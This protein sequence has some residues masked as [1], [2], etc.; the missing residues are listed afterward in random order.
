MYKVYSDDYLLYSDQLNNLKIMSPQLQLEVGKIDYFDFEVYPNH[1]YYN[2]INKLKS[3]I[4]VYQ[5]DDIIFRGRARNEDKGFYNQKIFEC[6]S[7]LSFLNDSIQ[8]PYSFTGD[9]D[10][11]FTS[12]INTHNTQ[13]DAEHQFTVGN[14]TVTDSN[15]YLARSSINPDTSFNVLQEKLID[16]YGGYLNVRHENGINYIDYLEDFTE[17]AT[18]DIELN[19][20]LMDLKTIVDTENFATYLIP[21]GAK[22]LDENEQETDVRLDITTVNDNVDFIYNATAASNYGAIWKSYTWDDVTIADNLLTKAQAY[23]D[24]LIIMSTTFEVTAADLATTNNNID[25]Y[26][27]GTYVTVTS[28]LHGI[29]QSFLITKLNLNLLE[30]ANKTISLN[31]IVK[32]FTDRTSDLNKLENTLVNRIE[33][34]SNNTRDGIYSLDNRLSSSIEQTSESILM[35]VSDSYYSKEESDN[36]FAETATELNIYKDEVEIKFTEFNGNLESFESVTD[37]KFTTID[38][39]IRF[40][41]GTIE[42]GNNESPLVLV[43]ENDRIVFKK[44]NVDMSYWDMNLETFV[45]GNIYVETNKEARFGNFAFKPRTNGSLSFEKVGG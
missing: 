38:K 39:Y 4:V 30:P 43:H 15:G 17:A 7:D 25:S 10:D 31:G 41:D 5:D 9:I 21:Y 2:M 27:V 34:V 28:G 18:Q 37:A 6:E 40:V 32:N 3:I 44:N 23:L 29:D 13:V 26:K 19:K 16:M 22:L 12:V 11:F 8:R 33:N 35:S 20:N 1:A 42:I 45:V 36:L 24:N 14:I